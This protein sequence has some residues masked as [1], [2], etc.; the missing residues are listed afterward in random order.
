MTERFCTGVLRGS[1]H[2]SCGAA[3]PR[4]PYLVLGDADDLVVRTVDHDVRDGGGVALHLGD[5]AVVDVGV[6]DPHGAVEP[7]CHCQ[8]EKHTLKAQRSTAEYSGIE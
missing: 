5:G 2:A 7:S 6:P 8:A 1:E 4:R 3:R